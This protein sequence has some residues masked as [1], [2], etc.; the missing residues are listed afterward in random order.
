MESERSKRVEFVTSSA[1]HVQKE[2]CNF[3]FRMLRKYETSSGDP[4]FM[5]KYDKR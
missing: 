2:Q 1:K 5:F 3:S 4:F